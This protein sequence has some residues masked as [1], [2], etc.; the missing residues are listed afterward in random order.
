MSFSAFQLLSPPSLRLFSC[1]LRQSCEIELLSTSRQNKATLYL[2][3]NRGKEPHRDS[4]NTPICQS[5]ISSLTAGKKL[6]LGV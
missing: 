2:A 6:I 1:P 5:L 4:G 3:A